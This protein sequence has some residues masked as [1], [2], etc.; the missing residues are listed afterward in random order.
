MIALVITAL[1]TGLTSSALDVAVHSPGAVSESD[2]RRNTAERQAALGSRSLHVS[3][4]DSSRGCFQNRR[5]LTYYRAVVGMWRD[6]MGAAARTAARPSSAVSNR[7][8]CPRVLVLAK[9]WRQKAIVHRQA[10]KRW[11]E[12]RTLEEFST[13]REAVHE[14]QRAYPGTESW[15]LSCSADEGGWGR[16]VPNSDGF[17]PGGWLQ[18]Y[19]STFW[20]MYWAAKAHAEA[21]GF[22]IPHSAASWYSPLG[23]A[24]AGAWGVTH[25]RRHEWA[26][27][28]C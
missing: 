10:W 16:W 12:R 14:A 1:G 17:P 28:G 21:R 19:E 2:S 11:M 8:G 5:G 6:K 22:R 26:G 27:S 13:W 15:L 3:G 7:L 18:F 20:R 23:Q 9:R 25:G 24:L 4:A